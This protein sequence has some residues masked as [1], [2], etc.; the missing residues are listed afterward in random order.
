M[1]RRAVCGLVCTVMPGSDDLDVASP[2]PSFSR[3]GGT[4]GIPPGASWGRFGPDDEVGTLN[5]AGPPEVLHAA[6]LVEAGEVYPLAWSNRLPD[7]PL[8]GREPAQHRRIWKA[9]GNDD[10]LDRFFPQR[11]T[12]WDALSHVRH[13][14]HG[15]YN[16]YTDEQ[17]T[18]D[19]AERLGVHNIAERGIVGRFLLV[20][21][22]AHRAVRGATLDCSASDVVTVDELDRAIADQGSAVQAGDILLLRFGW[23]EWYEAA[24]R[25]TRERL[26]SGHHF[27]APGLE[28]A[29]RT[30]AW[31]WDHRLSA[32]A[33]DVPALEVLP[34]HFRT[35]A[36][37]LHYRLIPLLGLTVGELFDLSAL[38]AR[39]RALGRWTGLF[40]S[41]PMNQPGGIGSPANALGIL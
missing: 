13:P 30:A 22:V 5:F 33:S 19:G 29:E 8:F 6:R 40:T 32:V 21:L 16:G 34:A 3:L 39:C 11:S 24:D 4:D 38:A 10:S 2:F 31:L 37:F 20:D 14:E 25:A 15:F 26:G 18:H 9:D 27:P 23:T 7:P 17:V 36:G 1:L 35:A 41:A 12:Q 28:N